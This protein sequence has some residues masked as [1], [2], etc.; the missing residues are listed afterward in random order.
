MPF[1]VGC[2]F[3]YGAYKCDVVSV[4]EMAVYIHGVLIFCRCL[5]D[6]TVQV[7]SNFE[8]VMLLH[9]LCFE[10]IR[11]CASRKRGTGGGGWV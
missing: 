7:S 1:Y 2:L 5:S 3:L 4:I 8:V 6:F 11:F 9:A 10:D